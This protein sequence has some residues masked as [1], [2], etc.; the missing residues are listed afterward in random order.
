MKCIVQ[1]HTFRRALIG[2][3]VAC[4]CIF[5]FVPP[6]VQARTSAQLD[7]DTLISLKRLGLQDQ[8][9]RG[10]FSS[11]YLEF[12]LPLDW[13]ISGPGELQL[14][15]DALLLGGD[16]N[17]TG[18]N[19]PITATTI[20]TATKPSS[21]ATALPTEP[22]AALSTINE[23]STALLTI[24]IND[25]LVGNVPLERYGRRTI[26]LPIPPEAWT[27][28]REDGLHF[29]YIELSDY[30]RCD[31][32]AQ[33]VLYVRDT[34]Q[35]IVPHTA[36]PLQ[37]SLRQLP[38]PF[39]Q[40]ALN[41]DTAMLVVPDR[42]TAD[43]LQAAMTVAAGFGR[44]SG[45]NLGLT[46]TTN[47]DLKTTGP[48]TT[49]LIYVGKADSFGNDLSNV[50]WPHAPEGSGFTD[51]DPQDGLLQMLPSPWNPSQALLWVSSA[52]DLGLMKAARALSSGTVRA[53]SDPN[54]SIVSQVRPPTTTNNVP[55]DWTLAELGYDTQTFA[56]TGS[57]FTS[58]QFHLP[59][60]YRVKSDAFF[61]IDFV[62]SALLEYASSGLVLTLNDEY[63]GSAR[64]DD[65]S[66]VLSSERIPL[67]TSAFRS[68]KNTLGVQIDLAPR[69]A[70]GN[71]A[72]L[73]AS[74]RPESHL[75]VP[76]EPAQPTAADLRPNLTRFPK[77]FNTQ[78][79]LSR[80]GLVVAPGDA[81]GWRAAAQVA[82]QLGRDS[83][84]QALDL[85]LSF[86]DNV[87][88]A[89]RSAKHL[90]VIGRPSQLALIEMMAD[91]LPAP[92]SPGSDVADDASNIEYRV[93][94]NAD[95]GYLELLSS[96][97]NGERT[98]LAVLGNNDKGLEQAT[99]ALIISKMRGQ[100]TGNLAIINNDK[101]YAEEVDV[102]AAPMLP[103]ATPEPT[104]APTAASS[105]PAIPTWLLPV[106]AIS[107]GLLF[108]LLSVA[109]YWWARRRLRRRQPSI[110]PVDEAAP[111]AVPLAISPPPAIRRN[112]AVEL[113]PFPLQDED[114]P[115]DDDVQSSPPSP[116]SS[117]S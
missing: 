95:V 24:K 53:L 114:D 44:M 104:P 18:S 66:T 105:A 83:A 30:P 78:P 85:S 70:C 43:E 65:A 20:E 17:T 77:P 108:I 102:R 99:R 90:V 42:P 38:L 80:L 113:T 109:A 7:P 52:T 41:P 14:D 57:R 62:H 101:V 40:R 16:S 112:R 4:L 56:G 96:P 45:G 46:L 117:P 107:I 12:G 9:M 60:G 26:S 115:P 75:H 31:K 82:F 106:A 73:W 100:L 48:M 91:A 29:I 5:N 1:R 103:T 89:M 49:H 76:I 10:P 88:E 69:S 15:V 35:L 84:A 11:S 34:S 54:V 25:V 47:S 79:D 2:W 51:V 86:A 36:A 87:P 64:F 93:P 97:W 22:A 23:R 111:P 13:A 19:D 68:G 59:D 72:R 50:K 28:Q 3:L 110:V 71:T 98:V 61:E 116:S 92:F 74:V 67:P 27:T 94:A 55:L 63:I 6:Q 33:V 32:D 81:M 58:F 37:P 8:T 39:Y 21:K